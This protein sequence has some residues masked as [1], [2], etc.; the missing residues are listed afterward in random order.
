MAYVERSFL[1]NGKIWERS[2]GTIEAF[3]EVGNCSALTLGI[4][5]EEASLPNYR[6][7]GGEANKRERITAVAMNV[8]AHDFNADN[9]AAGMRGDVSAVA[10][11]SVASEVHS[12]VDSGLIRTTKLIDKAQ[13]VEVTGPSGTPSH[14]AGTDYTITAA[15]IEVIQGGGISS[16]ADVEITYESLATDVIDAL[17]NSGVE[18]EIVFDGLNDAQSGEPV[19]VD[20]W[21]AKPGTT[22]SLARFGSGDGALSQSYAV[23]LDSTKEA[24]GESGY[25]R[26]HQQAVI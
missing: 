18:K 17:M 12:G 7:G 5:S 10:T 14:V 22:D 9:I 3:R 26:V 23:L 19:V 6:G 21:R 4:T 8:T 20:V 24:L 2:R 16:S 13:P 11:G 1:G 25:F 15:G